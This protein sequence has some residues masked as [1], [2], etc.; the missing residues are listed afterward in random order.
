MAKLVQNWPVLVWQNWPRHRVA[1]KHQPR[2]GAFKAERLSGQ[3]LCLW[4]QL[5]FLL[6]VWVWLGGMDASAAL[7]DLIVNSA[8]VNPHI[9][10]RTFTSTN[11]EVIEG[12]VPVGTRQLL[13]FTTESPNIGAGDL[14]LGDPTTNSLFVW[15]PCHGHYHFTNYAQYTLLDSNFN[16]VIAGRKTAFCLEDVVPWSANA[17]PYPAY[18]CNFQ[19]IQAGWADIYDDSLP[20]QW[21]DITGLPAGNYWLQI[22]VNPDNIIAE[23]DTSNNLIQVPVTVPAQCQ[24]PAND[25]F[26]NAQVITSTPGTAS[27]YNYCAS[28]ESGEP[29]IVGNPGGRSIWYRWTAPYSGAV[30]I[31]TVGSDFDT[32]LGV[33]TGGSV[34]TLSQLAANDDIVQ[35]VILQSRVVFTAQ[36]GVVYRIAVDGWNDG[37]TIAVGRVQLN[38]NPPA[39]D[40][41]T[42]CQAIIG[43]SGTVAGYTIGATKEPNEPSHNANVGGHSVWYCWTA[44]ADGLEIFDTI[45]S[46]FDTLLAVYTGNSVDALTPVVSNDNAN[47]NLTSQVHFNAASN[48]TYHIAVD[49]AFGA[50]GNLVLNWNPPSRLAIQRVSGGAVQLTVTGGLG[51]YQIQVSTNLVQWQSRTN[52]TMTG[53]TYQYTDTRA[54]AARQGFYRAVLVP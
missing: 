34:N 32:V 20:C 19:G 38:L 10:Q 51:N 24:P 25:L 9:E 28:K 18:N 31:T 8:A 50:M 45:G 15:S 26:A 54:A 13:L 42:N 14:V 3:W 1:R 11:C 53:P 6:M 39:N 41:F 30:E 35:A 33:Y 21:I 48:T 29:N 44:P 2:W 7:P 36:A 37:Q 27:G 46:D 47:G 23:S 52:F 40:F 22:I 17:N 5:T 16:A 49:G 43:R 12:C 4:P